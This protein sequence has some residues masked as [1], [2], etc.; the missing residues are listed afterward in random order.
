MWVGRE[1]AGGW[2]GGGTSEHFRKRKRKFAMWAAIRKGHTRIPSLSH[3][4]ARTCSRCAEHAPL[5]LMS[6]VAA[7]CDP[8]LLT[9]QATQICRIAHDCDGWTETCGDTHP[10]TPHTVG[11]VLEQRQSARCE[12]GS[13]ALLRSLWNRPNV[14]MAHR[15]CPGRDSWT[16]SPWNLQREMSFHSKSP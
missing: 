12:Q 9:P 11:Q 14:E 8:D 5:R 13:Q 4:L 15:C 1:R 10:R 16:W 7:P 3:P 2:V 6:S